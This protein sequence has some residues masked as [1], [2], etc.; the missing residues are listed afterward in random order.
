LSTKKGAQDNKQVVLV[1][2]QKHL[3]EKIAMLTWLCVQTQ[4]RWVP[5]WKWVMS[6]QGI[7]MAK[8]VTHT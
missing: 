2:G 7:E 3:G 8:F 1:R 6:R 4:K 5:S